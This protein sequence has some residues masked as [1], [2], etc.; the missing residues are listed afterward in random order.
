MQP[1][2]DLPP[3]LHE[4]VKSNPKLKPLPVILPGHEKFKTDQVEE[5]SASEQSAEDKDDTESGEEEGGADKKE[6][7]E[8]K[9]V[10]KEDADQKSE[11]GEADK[12]EKADSK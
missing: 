10:V 11:V 7:E 2:K 12:A 4:T 8:G 6:G 5:E 9:E 1:S 3:N